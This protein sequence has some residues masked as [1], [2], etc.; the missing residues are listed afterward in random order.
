MPEILVFQIRVSFSS[1]P[2]PSIN[3]IPFLSYLFSE[4]MNA[5]IVLSGGK[6]ESLGRKQ[7]SISYSYI[8]SDIQIFDL[9]ISHFCRHIQEG[10]VYDVLNSKW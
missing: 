10:T 3:P 9:A 5:C 8:Y 4:G 6:Q 7:K 1:T 2:P